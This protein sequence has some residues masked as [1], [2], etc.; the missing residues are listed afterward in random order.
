MANAVFVLCAATS[1][2]CAALLGRG[3]ARSR[4]RLLLWSALCFVVLA[5]NNALLVID[6]IILARTDLDLLRDVTAAGGPLL[7]LVGLVLESEGQ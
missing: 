2:G 1:L 7:L 6:E 5:V 4:S 3:Y